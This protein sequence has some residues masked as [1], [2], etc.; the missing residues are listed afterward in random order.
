MSCNASLTGS[1]SSSL[2][3]PKR[4]HTLQETASLFH[5]SPNLVNRTADG[6]VIAV[7][8]SCLTGHNEY[9]W[10]MDYTVQRG[11]TW[12]VVSSKFGSFVV[13]MPEK[14]LTASQVVTLDI[15]CGCTGGGVQVITY[16]IQPGDTLFTVCSHFGADVE[17]T[18]RL[19]SIENPELII[20]GDIVFIPAPD[21]SARE[22]SNVRN[23]I[24][25]GATVAATAV[26]ILNISIL[27][28]VFYFKRKGRNQSDEVS[29]CSTFLLCNTRCKQDTIPIFNP[30][31]S[32]VFSYHEV[33]NA[34]NNFNASQ[35]IGQGAYGSVYL[36][37]L[38]GTEVA[39]KQMKNTK[40][41]EFLA[42]LNILCKVHHTNLIELIGYAAGGDSLFLVYEYAHN[43]ALSDHLHSP[44]MKGYASLSLARRVQIAL[45]AAKGLEYIHMYTKP[46]YVHRDI[47]TSNIL[48]D[49]NFRAKIADFGL[50]KLLECSPEIEAATSKI[51]GT[52]GYLAPE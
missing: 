2:Y 50:V 38:K 6:Y 35:K 18:A 10:H 19:N 5:V 51:V 44:I 24:I 42:E 22:V 20:T 41:K 47:K 12:D 28:W 52:F 1:C 37:Q 13:E 33:C 43:G 7:N 25:L 40:S 4:L 26:V 31:R 34:T 14:T 3:V 27:L 29:C 30:D 9:V 15:L 49:S 32:T 8:C 46:F 16:S 39:I 17:Q 21:S 45:D 48:L 11:D 36:G 23:R